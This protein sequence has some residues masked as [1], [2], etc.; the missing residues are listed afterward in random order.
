MSFR[1]YPHYQESGVPW[2]GQTPSSWQVKGFRHLFRESTEK[3][4]DEVVGPMLSVSGYRGVEVKEYDDEN[5]RRLDGELI[6]YRIVRPGQL[7]VNTMWLNYAG[8]GISLHEGHVSPA[9]R[10]YDM[11]DG[12]Q[13]DRRF[14][15][16]LLRSAIYVQG[17]TQ[18]LTGVRPN[19]LQMS[20][21]DLM[22]FPV[23]LPPLPE[24][25]AIATF[26]DRETGKIDALVEEQKRLIEL[27]KEKRQAVISHA[28]TKG[29]NSDA[30]MKA[31]GIE[32]LGEV[33]EHW[34]VV[35]LRRVLSKIEQ[36]WSP[37][38]EERSPDEGE[39]AVMKTS[40]VKGGNFDPAMIK[41][42]SGEVQ[43]EPRYAVR[44][45]DLLMIRGNGSRELV[46]GAAYVAI[47]PDR[48][49]LP[50]LLYRLAY[51]PERADGK[52]LS[53][54]LGSRGLRHQIELAARGIDIL[55]IAQPSIAELQVAVPPRH[56]Q[57]AIVRALD[58][59]VHQLDALTN[60]A[61][62]AIDLLQERRAALI[63]AAVT[64][65]IDVRGL[66]EAREAAE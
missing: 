22:G 34:E 48:C 4:T 54:T 25:T 60:E 9:Y 21:D 61:Q 55:K 10:A 28:V 59:R 63:S 40:A 18:L 35:P 45:G 12:R 1:A 38:S 15:H 2:L 14:A 13:L 3:I 27:L 43:P 36:G 7:V 46:G 65:K 49:M 11:M 66:V 64:G 57:V 23:L 41:A 32:W 26:L 33:P 44:D 20:R 42:I 37:L 31:S 16:H 47:A 5:R 62:R 56:E 50:D 58:A 30:P 8:L 19:S 6:G 29:L 52:Y 51:M 53:Y 24:Q 39:W 17:Y